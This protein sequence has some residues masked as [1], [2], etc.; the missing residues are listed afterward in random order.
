MILK[1]ANKQLKHP[2][3]LSIPDADWVKIQALDSQDKINQK[4]LDLATKHVMRHGYNIGFCDERKVV[5]TLDDCMKCGVAKG[6]GRGNENLARWED[7]KQ[8]HINYG[9]SPAKVL[10]NTIRDEKI[11][12]KMNDQSE[13]EA[14][15]D[16]H[17]FAESARDARSMDSFEKNSDDVMKAIKDKEN[18]S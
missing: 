4:I 8:K 13:A 17:T 11:A 6:W 5:V 3:E 7:C 10:T 14:R 15:R 18:K 9:Y 16:K 2:I 12:A 1:I